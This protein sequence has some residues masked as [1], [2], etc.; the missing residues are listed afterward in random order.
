MSNETNFH[1]FTHITDVKYIKQND[2]NTKLKFV[3]L[4]WK[5]VNRVVSR[6]D[7]VNCK[8]NRNSLITLPSFFV[9]F[10]FGIKELNQ[11]HKG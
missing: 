8:W 6:S 10:E 11:G 5:L 4:N 9:T 7:S 1:D 3:L 2:E